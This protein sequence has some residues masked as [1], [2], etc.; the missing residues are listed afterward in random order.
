MKAVLLLYVLVAV[1]VDTSLTSVPWCILT[2][3]LMSLSHGEAGV[4]GVNT[5]NSIYYRSNTFGIS[6][7]QGCGWNSVGGKL[8]QLDVGHNVVWGV[9]ADLKVWYRDGISSTSTAGT[10][11]VFVLGV[12]KYVSVGDRNHVWGISIS[13]RI[14]IRQGITD[15][16]KG[17]TQW[18]EI[19]GH[20]K[21]V[22]VGPSGVWVVALD[23]RVLYRVGTFGDNGSRG[24]RWTQVSASTMKFLFSGDGVV[25][26]IHTSGHAYR[27]KGVTAYNPT[28]S[29]WVRLGGDL[30]S[31]ACYDFDT[32][33]GTTRSSQIRVLDI[34]GCIPGSYKLL[35]Y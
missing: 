18:A 20:G 17:G 5:A 11:W 29:A 35:A 10:R 9:S 27:R 33:W 16:R 8:K 4:W 13:N 30:E 28:G 6:N 34:K 15:S 12:L 7:S 22:S 32:V 3:K 2:G 14:Y 26:A 19:G 21:Q 25:C 23:N 31:V 1:S 24:S